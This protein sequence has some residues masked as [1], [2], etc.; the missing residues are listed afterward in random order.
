MAR[1]STYL[2]FKVS[3][4]E[5]YVESM[6]SD[7]SNYACL[8]SVSDKPLS[9]SQAPTA[10]TR[11]LILTTGSPVNKIL[12]LGIALK[13]HIRGIDKAETKHD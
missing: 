2:D 9:L 11:Y 5:S 1:S 12:P 4:T 7:F 13:G 6:K 8:L 10:S 3:I